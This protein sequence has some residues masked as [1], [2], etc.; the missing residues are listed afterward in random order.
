M[1]MKEIFSKLSQEADEINLSFEKQNEL[2][3]TLTDT[4]FTSC[5]DLLLNTLINIGMYRDIPDSSGYNPLSNMLKSL[6]KLSKKEI[7]YKRLK[8]ERMIE[9]LDFLQYK[10]HAVGLTFEDMRILLHNEGIKNLIFP[11]LFNYPSFIHSQIGDENLSVFQFAVK[12]GLTDWLEL[13]HKTGRYNIVELAEEPTGLGVDSFYLAHIYSPYLIPFLKN[14]CHDFKELNKNKELYELKRGVLSVAAQNRNYKAMDMIFREGIIKPCNAHAVMG[15]DFYLDEL[16]FI[17]E[18]IKKNDVKAF[19]I[20]LKYYSNV[21]LGFFEQINGE[22]R[23]TDILEKASEHDFKHNNF[24]FMD[25]I[26]ECLSNTPEIQKD[27][28][29]IINNNK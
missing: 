4:A 5:S 1:N 11:L 27:V 10:I 3:E 22:F 23:V 29:K 24:K 20:C 6:I 8:I 21:F 28:N 15:S 2:A 19:K 16:P 12:F 14:E 13:I 26:F 18:T 17:A 7:D 9:L 25:L